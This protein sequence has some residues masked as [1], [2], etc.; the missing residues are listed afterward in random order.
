MP[1]FQ[2]TEKYSTFGLLKKTKQNK[3]ST[4]L[5][6]M[7]FITEPNYYIL[8][9]NG[10]MIYYTV[11]KRLCKQSLWHK[12][13]L[14]HR[15]LTTNAIVLY[16]Y[17][18]VRR[19]VFTALRSYTNKKKLKK[20]NQTNIV[21]SLVN[22]QQGLMKAAVA[23]KKGWPPEATF[24]RVTRASHCCVVALLCRC[25]GEVYLACLPL[26]YI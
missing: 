19:A 1:P 21:A 23:N 26:W 18:R 13:R 10:L 3:N 15:R 9:Q 14:L 12:Y 8:L 5:S 11:P 7:R 20:I 25:T 4:A 24:A 6:L 17:S 2:E 16:Y 22:S